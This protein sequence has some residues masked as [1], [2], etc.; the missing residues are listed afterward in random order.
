MASARPRHSSFGNLDLEFRRKHSSLARP[1][2]LPERRQNE[3]P[4][5]RLKNSL[6]TSTHLSL[7]N[8]PFPFNNPLLSVGV[9]RSEA[10]GICGAPFGCPK[11]LASTPTENQGT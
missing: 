9:M 2:L 10:R 6:P 4:H 11:S 8:N 3:P 5:G 7:D 1:T